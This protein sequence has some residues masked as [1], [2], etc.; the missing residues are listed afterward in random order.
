[1]AVIFWPN[2]STGNA[3]TDVQHEQLWNDQPDGLI[4]GQ[5]STAGAITVDNIGNWT[6]TAFVARILGK[7]ISSTGES[8]Q[9]ATAGQGVRYDLLVLR[10][11][12]GPTPNV[13]SLFRIAGTLG[14]GYPAF[15]RTAT[16]TDL[17]LYLVKMSSSPPEVTDLRSKIKPSRIQVPSKVA[18][19]RLLPMLYDAAELTVGPDVYRVVNGALQRID[20]DSGWLTMDPAT[21]AWVVGSEQ[22]RVRRLNETVHLTGSLARVGTLS[23]TD[24]DG[25]HLTGLPGGIVP[26]YTHRWTVRAG[27]GV[28]TAVVY[29]T[30]RTSATGVPIAAG[31]IWLASTNAAV[32]AGDPIN[33]ATSFPA[34]GAYL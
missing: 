7:G 14:G 8:G 29:A 34:S 24:P 22:P 2:A 11:D 20:G 25:S 15:Q 13:A 9:F 26:S 10:L 32:N 31:E 1:V 23:A 4:S 6:T 21:T 17:P 5:A 19:D 12:R 30:A 28:G 33:I 3:V 16:I 18:A 27:G